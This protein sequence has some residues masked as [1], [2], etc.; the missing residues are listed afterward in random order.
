MTV[1]SIKV[2]VVRRPTLKLKVL[3]R[4]P[5]NV[6]V[7]SPILL[8]RTGGN[9]GFGFD[10][11]AVN[12]AITLDAGQIISGTLGPAR[13]P[14][15][16]ASTLGGV[17]SIAAVSHNWINSISTAGV[18]SLSQPA[19]ADISGT[20]AA[21]Q[22]PSPSASTLG[23]IQSIAA[24]GSR[25]INTISTSG[26]PSATQPAFSDI[27]GQATLAQLPI[28]AGASG[29]VL[30]FPPSG[31]LTGV[32][33]VL[34]PYG[35]A[36]STAG[37]TTSGL[38][39]AINYA[40]NNGFPLRV[41]GHG[42]TTV[43]QQT[44]TLNSTN[45]V[46]GLTTAAF[47]TAFANG[48]V[49]VTGA[50]IPA[51]TWVVSIDSASQIHLNNAA[52]ATASNPLRFA[53]NLVFLAC[54]SGIQFPPIEQ[55]SCR[56]DDV[57]ITFNSGV[58]GPCFTF[59]SCMIVSFEFYG[60]QIV[61]QPATPLANSNLIYLKPT[62]PVTLDGI[63]TVTA[64]R[65][66]FNN[67]A[68]PASG[69]NAQAVFACDISSGSI[70]NNF[71]GSCELNG[72]GI[73][74]TPN[75][76]WG[77][78]V[79]GA[80]ASTTFEQNII[81]IS[82]IHLV[83]SAGIQIGVN[84]TNA[85]SYRNNVWRIGGIRPGSAAACVSTWGS[86]D[87]FYIG[88]CTNEEAGGNVA[89]GINFQSSATG[90]L[91]IVGQM[92]G[93]TTPVIYGAANN[94]VCINGQWQHPA[95][96]GTGHLAPS[97]QLTAQLTP[98]S[99][100][101]SLVETTL[102]TYTMPAGTL[103]VVGRKLKIKAWGTTGA[104]ANGKTIRLYLGATA[105]YNSTAMTTNNGS[106]VLEAEVYKTGANSQSCWATSIFINSIPVTAVQATAIAD[107]AAIIIKVTGQNSVATAADIVCSG[108]SIEFLN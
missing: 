95:G 89:Q 71:F 42:G 27:S 6:T 14:N 51:F 100:P 101:A 57:N 39:E 34:D 46:T 108:M 72:T 22:L 98:A 4:F 36:L 43:A 50:G 87:Q 55:W 97:G 63:S 26:V 65:F 64:S 66:F 37:T 8:D 10:Q 1:S 62:N 75:T 52:T 56:F 84:S 47:S 30:M 28:A 32:W 5:A 74:A 60:G 83:A 88:A 49:Y 38:Q 102:Q 11:N 79:T 15:P 44:G 31:Q 19:F 48:R 13:L 40:A 29:A 53:N 73:G 21:T 54:N 23:G 99:T 104:D 20:I 67:T 96:G 70:A 85:A 18:P 78:F 107:T 9:Y 35:N 25:W 45:I 94:A 58:T 92:V 81:D 17:K 69:G 33:T 41:L 106:W 12:A 90:N 59:D 105:I 2:K 76:N 7:A 82:D 86:G 3:P 61:G 93:I 24:V 80:T 91:A 77:F 68:Y 103:D 16:T